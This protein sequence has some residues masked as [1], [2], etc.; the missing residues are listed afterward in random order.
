MGC[1]FWHRHKPTGKSYSCHSVLAF[2]FSMVLEA[3]S[4]VL[5]SFV[6]V[7]RKGTWINVV[8]H[9]QMEQKIHLFVGETWKGGQV[10]EELLSYLTLERHP[11]SWGRTHKGPFFLMLFPNDVS[12]NM[13][14]LCWAH[15]RQLCWLMQPC[16]FQEGAQMSNAVKLSLMRPKSWHCSHCGRQSNFRM[17]C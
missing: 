2:T 14:D 9:S 15:K 10:C 6:L 16:R 8:P 1:Y 13:L 7:I 12:F 11:S 3:C 4:V 17:M 5:N